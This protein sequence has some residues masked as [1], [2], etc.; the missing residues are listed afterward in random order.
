MSSDDRTKP[1]SDIVA[2]VGGTPLIKLNRI[3]QGLGANIYLKAEFM[4]PL[5]SVKDRVA[6]A[7]IGA[8]EE[9][10][11]I[12]P[13]AVIIEPTS[14]N[15][16]IALAFVCAQRG[17]KLIVTMP[18]TVSLE[19]RTLLR[20]LGAEVVLT[21]GGEGM[22]GA[23]RRADELMADNGARAFMPQQ[24]DNPANPG[25]HRDTTA[26]EIWAALGGEVDAFVAGVGTGGT[27]TGVSEFIKARRPSMR[28][29][30]VEPAS[31]PVLS[32]G[33]PGPHLIQGIGA[34]FVPKNCNRDVIDE[35]L[36]VSDEEAIETARK[37][38]VTDG[39]LCGFST[40]ANVCAALR[41]ATRAEFASKN[42]VTVGCSAG[43]RY[44][45]TELAAKAR[46]EVTV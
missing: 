8:A 7:M 38:A 35:V 21:P 11:K 2:S 5:G 23:I 33:R 39:I 36:A 34:G 42:I 1:C 24:F 19:R 31:S 17:Y 4:N 30:A 25:A 10:G 41:I 32:G 26:P 13:G 46:S 20:M 37:L 44:L 12:G 43:E 9:Q 28:A 6:R 27:I 16:G 29:F 15:M 18:E 40:G 45:S 3:A 22:P 14:G